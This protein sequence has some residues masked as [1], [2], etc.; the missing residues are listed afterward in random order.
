MAKD[1][2]QLAG[3]FKTENT[4]W[5]LSGLLAE[6]NGLDRRALLRIGTWGAVAVGAVILAVVANETSL[7]WRHEQVAAE[8]LARQAQQLQ[9]L[10]KQSQNEARQ[11]AAAIETLNTDRDRLFS[12]VTVLEQ[13][14]D[15]VTGAIARQNSTQTSGQNSPQNSGQNSA[16]AA[17]PIG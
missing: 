10:S 5:L 2:D 11:I 13:G 3:A 1:S 6:E 12:R 8:D 14:L 17:P 16:A 15:S 9:S 7:G 4:G